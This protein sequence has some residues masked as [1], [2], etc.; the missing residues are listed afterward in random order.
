MRVVI[1]VFL[2]LEKNWQ[3]YGKKEICKDA[4]SLI[5]WGGLISLNFG[6]I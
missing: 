5:I 1:F 4:G 3:K 2:F 6:Q